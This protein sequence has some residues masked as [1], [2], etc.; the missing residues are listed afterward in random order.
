MHVCAGQMDTLSLAGT[1]FSI[2]SDPNEDNLIYAGNRLPAG[3]FEKDTT[4][5][6]INRDKSYPGELM[7]LVISPTI[8]EAD[9]DLQPDTLFLEDH[10]ANLVQFVDQSTE[11]SIWEWTFGNGFTSNKQNPVITFGTSGTYT[12]Q[13][14]VSNAAGCSSS[15]KTEELLVLDRGPAPRIE[16]Q[17]ICSGEPVVLSETGGSIRVYSDL[18]RTNLI[19]TGSVFQ[20]EAI[21]RD[22]AFFVTKVDEF[23]SQATAVLVAVRKPVSEF[24]IGLDTTNLSTR[25]VI[26]TANRSVGATNYSW[27]LDGVPVSTD[28]DFSFEYDPERSFELELITIDPSGCQDLLTQ[29]FQPVQSASPEVT[30][31][32]IC[33]N[34]PV[35]VRPVSGNIFYFYADPILEN[36]IH[37]GRVLHWIDSTLNRVFVTNVDSL[38]ES[39]PDTVTIVRDS[40]RAVFTLQ[41]NPLVLSD[42]NQVILT[43]HSKSSPTWIWLIDGVFLTFP[44]DSTYRFSVPG[45][46][47]IGLIVNSENRCT[48]SAFQTLNVVEVTGIEIDSQHR[49]RIFPNPASESIAVELGVQWK[50]PLAITVADI[51]GRIVLH[52]QINSQPTVE[53]DLS[54]LEEGLYL[55]SAQGNNLNFQSRILIR[56]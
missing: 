45:D 48:D 30:D 40:V 26:R 4:F 8:P 36:L 16:D 2:Y 32:A 7:R 22:T 33:A 25:N 41:P 50:G 53:L 5:Y 46:Y 35:I 31:I 52:S 24:E 55:I 15:P 37:K 34:E 9:F 42:D 17:I 6:L 23:E 47:Q 12:V 49:V 10:P 54:N 13:L 11:A 19:F 44:G 38:K 1:L 3:P 21:E 43:N 14:T 27:G 20:S 39:S 28:A 51:A 56:H 29:S 18:E